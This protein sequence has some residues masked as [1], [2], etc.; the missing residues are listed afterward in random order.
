MMRTALLWPLL[1][2]LLAVGMCAPRPACATKNNGLRLSAGA[3]GGPRWVAGRVDGQ[4]S[5]ELTLTFVPLWS[6]STGMAVSETG[7]NYA[8]GEIAIHLIASLGGGMGYGA[9]QSDDDRRGGAAGHL[10]FGLPIP[11]VR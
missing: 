3:G 7:I 6:L 4:L 8:Y 2:L 5:T 10:F 9:F 11:L 1:P